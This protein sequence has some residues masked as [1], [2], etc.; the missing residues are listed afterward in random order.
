MTAGRGITHSE[1]FEAL[2]ARGGAM[3]GIQAWVALPAEQEEIDPS[4]SHHGPGDLP[5]Y[6]G[7]G[8]WARLIAGKAFGAEAKVAVHS[9][10]FYV[11]WRLDAGAKAQIPAEYPERAAFVAAGSVEIDGQTVTT[12][13]PYCNPANRPWSPG[14]SRP[15]SCCWAAN[16]SAIAS[17]SGT[18]SPR[19]GCGSKRQRQ[20][21]APAA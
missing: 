18:S 15:R 1:R 4:F 8:L 6:E 11:H 3:H 12:G 21:G 5:T 20:T 17:W 13:W 16:P 19:L 14:S 10:M 9:P 7:G 2:R